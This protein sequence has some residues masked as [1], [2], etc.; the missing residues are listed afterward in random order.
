MGEG[1]KEEGKDGVGPET[2]ERK[3]GSLIK[4]NEAG[5]GTVRTSNPSPPH[6]FFKFF[7]TVVAPL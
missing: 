2:E 5:V 6:F 3:Y 7:A 1:R 4:A